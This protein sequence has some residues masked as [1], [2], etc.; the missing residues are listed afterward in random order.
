MSPSR[1]PLFGSRAEEM[2]VLRVFSEALVRNL[3]PESLYGLDVNRCALNEIVALKGEQAYAHT[4]IILYENT[5]IITLY[6]FN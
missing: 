4:L 1:D 2:A 6:H 3:F 5:F